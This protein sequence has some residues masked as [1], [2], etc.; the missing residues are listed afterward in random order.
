MVT[1]YDVKPVCTS[2]EC[3]MGNFR[4]IF[5]ATDSKLDQILICIFCRV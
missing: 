2:D 5:L 4:Y 3:A 1:N